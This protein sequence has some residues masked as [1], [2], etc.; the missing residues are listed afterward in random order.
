MEIKCGTCETEYDT[1]AYDN[2]P[3][4]GDDNESL[5]ENLDEDDY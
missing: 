4:C 2:C 3:V 1:D 5:M